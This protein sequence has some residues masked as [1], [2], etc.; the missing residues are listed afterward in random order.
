MS[1]LAARRAAARPRAMAAA[2]ALAAALAVIF[3]VVVLA[4]IGSVI[5]PHSPDAQD[6]TVSLAKPGSAHWL[7][8]DMLGR[9][10]LS[11]VFAGARPAIL[12]PTVITVVSLIAG[13]LLGLIA[14]FRGGRFDAILMRWVDV[15][16]AVPGLLVIIVVA[17]AFDGGYWLAVGLLTILTIPFDARVIRGATLEQAN[18][19]YIEAARTIG[20]SDRRIV[21]LHLWPNIAGVAVA[22]SSLVFASSL[23]SLAGLSFLG[24]GVDPGTPDWGLMLAD[25]QTYLFSNPVACLAPGAMIV[26]T[27]TAVTLVGDWLYT[28]IASRGGVR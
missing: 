13:N 28:R 2:L 7:G 23:V 5:A 15:M 12:G 8:T 9:D 26:I 3:G 25:G 10:V 21:L 14:G 19:P 22:N 18:R 1:A 20:V 11:R 17:G 24:L 6:V 4:L 27:A 16:W